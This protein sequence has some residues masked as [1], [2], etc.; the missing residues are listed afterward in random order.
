[1]ASGGARQ[2]AGRKTKAEELGLPMLIDD[3][4]GES[5][6]RDLIKQLYDQAKKGSFNHAQLLLA[7]IYGKPTEHVKSDNVT[8]LNVKFDDAIRSLISPSSSES[9]DNPKG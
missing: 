8:E 5:G 6:K 4:I 2:G 7:Y 9:G 1:M 3:V